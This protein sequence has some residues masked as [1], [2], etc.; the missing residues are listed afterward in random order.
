MK[1]SSISWSQIYFQGLSIT[2]E[3][4]FE[5]LLGCINKTDYF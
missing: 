3:D 1:Y 5:H 4:E 2:N